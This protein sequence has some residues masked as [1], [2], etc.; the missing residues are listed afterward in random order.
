MA[1]LNRRSHSA[2]LPDRGQPMFRLCCLLAVVVCGAGTTLSGASNGRATEAEIK[3]ALLF[4][5][6][7]FVEWPPA[8]TPPGTPIVIG[9]LGQ[10]PFGGALDRL[11]RT[12]PA[13]ER[14]VVVEH[15]RDARS[16]RRSHV[17]YI[18]PSERDTL[19]QTFATLEGRPILTVSD[20]EGFLRRGG[21]LRLHRN[22]EN[23]IRVRLNLEAA[24]ATRLTIS[25][26]LLRVVEVVPPGDE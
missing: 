9:I 13:G 14:Q 3:A 24:R 17:L 12:Q 2:R 15:F 25:A 4:N 18:H 19:Q 1:L 26:K 6:T 23:K 11:A 21:I 22:A 10:D 5:L 20:F 8:T 16:A 7:R